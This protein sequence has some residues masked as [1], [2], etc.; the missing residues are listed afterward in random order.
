MTT[1]TGDRWQ[2][3]V[4]ANPSLS[5]RF[6]L[7]LVISLLVPS[8]LLTPGCGGG[9][10]TIES[11]GQRLSSAG[12][13]A[14]G[15]AS[16]DGGGE[17]GGGNDLPGGGDPGGGDDLCEPE[18]GGEHCSNGLDEDCDGAIDCEDPDCNGAAA[19]AVCQDLGAEYCANGS[20]D[21]CDGLLDCDD[22]DCAADPSC[23]VCEDK[24]TCEANDSKGNCNGHLG[25]DFQACLAA[26]NSGGCSQAW[27]E[28]WC[29]RR[30]DPSPT[31]WE[32]MIRDWVT[33]RCEGQ[34]LTRLHQDRYTEYYCV[35]SSGC[36]THGCTTP[37]VVVFGRGERVSFLPD[38]GE[39]R[40]DLAAPGRTPVLRTDWPS[41][42]TPWLALDRDGDG[43][44]TSGQELFGSAVL[45]DGRPAANGFEALAALD[46]N[47]DG[48]IDRRDPAFYRLLLWAD[49]NGDRRS[50]P[51][52]LRSLRSA[53]LLSLA[54][55]HQSQPRCDERGN[56]EVERA[57]LRFR[58]L[59]GV[60]RE[61]AVVDVR[62]K[63]HRVLF[64][65]A[66]AMAPLCR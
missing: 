4:R 38:D 24:L 36:E 33:S 7:P 49:A 37:L 19:C 39:S 28:A 17:P 2:Q 22:P 18:P 53:G 51:A 66:L 10:V 46:A 47:G 1:K 56:C 25:D 63:E 55:S 5:P 48:Q 60:E 13:I 30:V 52:E 64:E 15:G 57:S 34:V 8:F 62:L 42:V 14:G 35:D 65:E 23:A 6:L 32:T 61:G 20:D 50:Q 45:I 44:I 3:D 40:F 11:G 58:D 9:E 12:D 27:L 31:R 21:D 43:A 16:S 26:G 41:A 54:L 29:S 59:A